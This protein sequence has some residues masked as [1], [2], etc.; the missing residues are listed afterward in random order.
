MVGVEVRVGEDVMEGVSVIVGVKVSVGVSVSAKVAVGAGVSVRAVAV[1]VA[2]IWGE[3]AQA[4]RTSRMMIG[5]WICLML[6]PSL[7]SS[8]G[9]YSGPFGLLT[10]FMITV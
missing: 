1:T 3:G 8:L 10:Y 2:P 7:L 9:Q 6:K 4:D 5:I